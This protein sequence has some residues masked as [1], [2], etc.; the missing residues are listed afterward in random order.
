MYVTVCW[1]TIF[2]CCF[3]H[4]SPT[5][6]YAYSPIG[7][8]A[9][10]QPWLWAFHC[11]RFERF[12]DSWNEDFI[13]CFC[14]IFFFRSLGSISLPRAAFSSILDARTINRIF[15]FPSR[16]PLEPTLQVFGLES[17]RYLPPRRLYSLTM[18]R[19]YRRC[20]FCTFVGS[21]SLWH[22]T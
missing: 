3:L 13:F 8:I 18:N 14:D 7:I 22:T 20:V 19:S 11:F 5:V 12:T 21:L 6:G 17:S 1:C 10:S 15:L 16:P 9:M 4:F 2:T